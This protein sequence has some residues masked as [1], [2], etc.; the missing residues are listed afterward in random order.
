MA[1]D[2]NTQTT[3][4]TDEEVPVVH[5]ISVFMER[6]A[7]PNG[8]VVYRYA[9]GNDYSGY[10]VDGLPHGHGILRGPVLT[11]VGYWD[12]GT[13]VQGLMIDAVRGSQFDIPWA[14]PS[15][16]PQGPPGLLE[17]EGQ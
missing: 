9:N 14:P 1:G 3:G 5:E 15:P 11:Y 12:S 13:F 6:Q 17:S 8:Y 10:M 16:R 4:M 2:N 7:K